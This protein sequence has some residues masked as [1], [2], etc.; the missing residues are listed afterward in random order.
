MFDSRESCES[1]TLPPPTGPGNQLI[2]HKFITE[3]G[4]QFLKL[5]KQS[6]SIDLAPLVLEKTKGRDESLVKCPC[7]ELEMLAFKL[8]G[9]L[10]KVH[11]HR[12]PIKPYVAGFI[13]LVCMVDY[14][15]RAKLVNHLCYH[16][17]KCKNMY[18]SC[19]PKLSPQAFQE[20]EEEEAS[21]AQHAKKLRKEGRSQ[22]YSPFPVERVSGPLLPDFVRKRRKCGPY[23]KTK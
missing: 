6:E 8:D 22:L 18:L 19:V 11:K 14:Q 16:S 23:K 7:C 10:A 1:F 13:C 17:A 12:N 9:H 20:E 3:Q 15:F 4:D 5:V 21:T 2:W